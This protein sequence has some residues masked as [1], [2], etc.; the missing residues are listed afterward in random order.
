MKSKLNPKSLSTIMKKYHND[1]QFHPCLSEPGDTI[2]NAPDGFVG[3]YRIFFKSGLRLLT[4]DFLK[5]VLDSYHLH[6]SQISH[7]GFQKIVCFVM[8]CSTLDIPP[9]ITIFYY[10][11]VTMSNGDW[12]SYS[13]CHVMLDIY[14]G[15]LLL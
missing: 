1:P 6:I 2:V 11:Y 5:T 15:F 13:V 3:V 7:N 14:D 8:L 9:S 4:F 12:V 10:F